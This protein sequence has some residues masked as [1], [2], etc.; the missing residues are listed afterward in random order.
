M[1][2]VLFC[3]IYRIIHKFIY[4]QRS[5]NTYIDEYSFILQSQIIV[6]FVSLQL[7]PENFYKYVIDLAKITPTN[8]HNKFNVLQNQLQTLHNIT[9]KS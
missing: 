2:V 1:P 6:E 8:K 3:I 5:I 7:V 9:Y 4:G